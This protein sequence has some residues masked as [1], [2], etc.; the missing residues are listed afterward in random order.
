MCLSAKDSHLQLQTVKWRVYTPGALF[1]Q[2]HA[3]FFFYPRLPWS[4]A[5][6]GP[7]EVPNFCSTATEGAIFH[8][9]SRA[10]A[11]PHLSAAQCALSAAP[12]YHSHSGKQTKVNNP[13]FANEQHFIKLHLHRRIRMCQ[14]E[15]VWIHMTNVS[16]MVTYTEIKNMLVPINNNNPKKAT[17]IS[18]K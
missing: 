10:I 8:P 6:H 7:H 18:V 15:A 4:N 9:L 13:L 14:Y 12:H 3:F 2:Q 16:K 5:A 1:V 11:A 17:L